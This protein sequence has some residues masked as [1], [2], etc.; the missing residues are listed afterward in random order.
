MSHFLGCTNVVV[1]L[2]L[3]RTFA[4]CTKDAAP[5]NMPFNVCHRE[6]QTKVQHEVRLVYAATLVL[7]FDTLLFDLSILTHWV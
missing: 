4:G 6:K 1:A 2:T 7:T 5:V 3:R